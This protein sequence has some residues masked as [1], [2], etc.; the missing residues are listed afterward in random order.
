MFSCSKKL[1]KVLCSFDTHFLFKYDLFVEYILGEQTSQSSLRDASS[2]DRGALGRPG[3]PCCSHRPNRAQSAGPCPNGQ[4]LQN[5]ALTKDARQAAVNLD[6]GAQ[7]FPI[8]KASL[9]QQSR[10]RL[11]SGR[12]PSVAIRDIS[13]RPE[14]VFPTRGAGAKRLRGCTTSHVSVPYPGC[15]KAILRTT[16][17]SLLRNATS[18]CRRGLG[19]PRNVFGF[20]RGSPFGRAGRK[21]A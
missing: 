6:S 2:P 3:Q 13:L 1:S 7:P 10:Y 19:S 9:V 11:A 4:Q 8:A 14:R 12:P 17:P 15:W 21:A 5:C 18:P 20:V 16:S